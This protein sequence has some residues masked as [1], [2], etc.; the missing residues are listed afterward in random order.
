MRKSLLRGIWPRTWRRRYAPG[1]FIVSILL[2]VITAVFLIH[3]VSAAVRPQLVALAQAKLRNQLTLISNEAVAAVL[4]QEALR[5]SDMVVMEPGPGGG[6]ATITTETVRLNNLR[7]SVM[8][9]VVAKVESL[10]I[11]S[12]GIP[13][14]AL[15][16]M[17]I[18][19][20]SG[21]DLPVQVLSVASAEGNYRNDFISA[22][23]NQTLHRV[24]LDITV[25]AD[26]LLPG[27][28]VE[29]F[30]STPV[31]VAETI[32]IGQVPQTYLELYK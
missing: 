32:I 6:I 3:R 22:G 10:D 28:V 11:H 16:G 8:A 17:D 24:I 12:L 5:Y 26:L 15:T 7:S 31:C 9:Q 27:G 20:G 13:L 29:T 19:A 14:G 18:F 1:Q 23:I 2:G 30:V 21:P 25:T 4:A